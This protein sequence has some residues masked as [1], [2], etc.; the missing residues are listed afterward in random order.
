MIAQHYSESDLRE[1]IEIQ[2]GKDKYFPEITQVLIDFKNKAIDLKRA[3]KYISDYAFDRPAALQQLF[4]AVTNYKNARNLLDQQHINF[5]KYIIEYWQSEPLKNELHELI[6]YGLDTVHVAN[7][8]PAAGYIEQINGYFQGSRNKELK[9]K[10]QENINGAMG[11]LD[12]CLAV[13]ERRTNLFLNHF[14]E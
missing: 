6:T 14:S 13:L 2:D 3:L 7:F 1:A 5:E 12:A 11:G 9:K 8:L 10:I 4:E